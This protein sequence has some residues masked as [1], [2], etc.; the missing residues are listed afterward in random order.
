MEKQSF[1][2]PDCAR[3]KPDHTPLRATDGFRWASRIGGITFGISVAMS[4]LAQIAI[5]NGDIA[6]TLLLLI[7]MILVSIVFD[8]VGVSAASCDPDEL[9]CCRSR[10]SP[11][12]YR[13]ALHMVQHAEKV[14]TFCSDVVGDMCGILSGACGMT[15]A[16][17]ISEQVAHGYLTSILVSAGI[18]AMTVGGKAWMKGYAVRYACE[19]VICASR[20]TLRFCPARRKARNTTTH[21]KRHF[22]KSESDKASRNDT[23]SAR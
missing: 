18:A 17:R 1:P 8:A 13:R 11:S 12:V 23:E 2:I 3:R 7:F 4:L 9:T 15:I 6:V 20:M 22:A 14:N 10:L 5:G 19:F 21:E 16:I